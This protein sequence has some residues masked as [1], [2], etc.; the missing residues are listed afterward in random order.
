MGPKVRNAPKNPT[1]RTGASGE[2]AQD[3][4][5]G[6]IHGRVDH[7]AGG[8]LHRRVLREH[9]R[10][11]GHAQ[12]LHLVHLLHRDVVVDRDVADVIGGGE[13]RGTNRAAVGAGV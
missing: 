6:G 4:H 1:Q 10:D 11:P 2:L 9:R 5:K 12:V 3:S 8:Q 13:L 7:D